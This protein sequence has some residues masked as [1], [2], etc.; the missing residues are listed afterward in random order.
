MVNY[1]VV[2]E[3]LQGA[4]EAI[5][6]NVVQY[7]YAIVRLVEGKGYM[8]SLLFVGSLSGASIRILSV[9]VCSL[10]CI[11]TMQPCRTDLLS[12]FCQGLTNLS[13]VE[14]NFDNVSSCCTAVCEAE[15]SIFRTTEA[16][17]SIFVL[18]VFQGALLLVWG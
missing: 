15:K 4:R 2:A 9:K 17:Q 8:Y 14:S 6:S 16:P 1:Q 11:L 10:Y 12:L 3:V 7:A 13:E 5:V 18:C